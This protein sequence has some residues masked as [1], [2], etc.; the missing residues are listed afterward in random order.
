MS[1]LYT[2]IEQQ[3]NNFLR[4]VFEDDSGNV[5]YGGII[6]GAKWVAPVIQFIAIL[7]FLFII[8]FVGQYLWNKGLVPAFSFVQEIEDSQQMLLTL[9]ALIMFF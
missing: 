9:F 4:L 6:P 5:E 2:L 1:K 7:V 8:L 3:V